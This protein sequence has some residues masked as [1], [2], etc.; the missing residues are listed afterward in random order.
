MTTFSN[1]YTYNMHNEN[2]ACNIH[3]YTR[4]STPGQFTNGESLACQEDRCRRWIKQT[5]PDMELPENSERIKVYQYVGTGTKTTPTLREMVDNLTEE[6]LVLVA[7]VD[8][9]SRNTIDALTIL[10]GINSMKVH[11]YSIGE[12]ADYDSELGRDTIRQALVSAHN[13]SEKIGRRSRDS[14]AFRRRRGDSIGVAPYGWK[15]HVDKQT[16]KRTFVKDTLEQRVIQK[17]LKL[18]NNPATR[19]SFTEICDRLSKSNIAYERM[20]RR[21]P[22]SP[23]SVRGAIKGRNTFNMKSLASG[24]A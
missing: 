1:T 12:N 11:F 3:I 13:E 2:K 17:I 9:F 8:R 15:A 22:W 4:V 18:R 20:K 19:M 21:R 14:I 10:D 16:R 7:N 5:Y 24:L 23:A 6:D